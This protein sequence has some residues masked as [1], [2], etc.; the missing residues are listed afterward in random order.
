MKIYII[1]GE[2]SGDQ[3]AAALIKEIK[4][5]HPDY[6]IRGVGGDASESAGL[7]LF[8]H[9]KKMAVMGFIEVL[10]K[11]RS[12]NRILKAIKRD[13]KSFGPNK[14]ILIDFPG[15]NLRLAKY[16]NELGIEVH[17]YIAPK[18]WAWKENRIR[19]LDSYVDRLYSILPFEKEYFNKKGITATYVGNPSKYM[20]DQY[21][22]GHKKQNDV[23]ALLPG[24][25]AQEIKANLQPMLRWATMHPEEQF[26]VS[27]APGF[28]K[29][30]YPSLP[31]NFRLESDMYS[32]LSH[33]KFAVVTSG[34]ATLETALFGVPQVVGYKTSAITYFI[35]RLLVKLKY[36]SLVN[37]ISG[38]EVVPELLQ[39]D[40]NPDRIEKAFESFQLEGI[41]RLSAD[42]LELRR[43]IGDLNP[44]SEILKHL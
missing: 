34:T 43:T 33:A 37:L 5:N 24:S 21:L 40:F 31:N 17:Y 20:V 11:L 1:S 25:R 6:S 42:Y 10:S 7:D 22:K 27:Q 41:D 3:H 29:R 13:I 38:K 36:I 44:T 16:A 18:V 39:A 19:K 32:L 28:D 12:L 23:I 30:D 15:M 2:T 14:I 26:V 35:G 4:T 8:S 9:Q